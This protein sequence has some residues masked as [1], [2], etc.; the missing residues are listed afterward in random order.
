M[1]C[2]QGHSTSQKQGGDLNPGIPGAL[3][4]LS[5]H[6]PPPQGLGLVQYLLLQPGGHTLNVSLTLSEHKLHCIVPICPF[7]PVSPPR[8]IAL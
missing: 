2:S 6:P 1:L 5:H 3:T 4:T 7:S 8:L